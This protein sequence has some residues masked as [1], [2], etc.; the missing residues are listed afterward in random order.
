MPARVDDLLASAAFLVAHRGSG[1]NWP[2]HTLTAYR[3][4]LAAGAA[5][6]EISVRA[7][8]DKV[9]VCHHDANLERTTGRPGALAELSYAELSTLRVDARPWLGEATPLEPIS[10]VEDVLAALPVGCLAFVEDKDGTNTMAL[11]DLLDRQPD[12]TRRFVW[13]QWGPARQVKAARERGYRSWGYFTPESIDRVEEFAADHDALGAYVGQDDQTVARLVAMGKPVIVW[14]VHTRQQRDRLRAL[15]V[16][17]LMCSNVPYVSTDR[18]AA[19]AT[20][21][22]T[23][24]R[25][26]GDL[27]P[28]PE[29]GWQGQPALLPGNSRVKLAGPAATPRY[30]LGSLA[31]ITVDRYRLSVGFDWPGPVADQARAGISLGLADDGPYHPAKANPSGCVQLW[32]DGSGAIGLSHQPAG[33]ASGTEL[34]R[35]QAEPSGALEV[36][37]EV[38]A[39]ELVLQVGQTAARAAR[40]GSLGGYLW[41]WAE[42]V[43]AAGALVGPVSVAAS[44]D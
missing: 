39:G 31:P 7:T 38:G 27:P 17:G 15:G 37:L 18:S 32:R 4:A 9:L 13:K 36:G 29:S 21:F 23:A 25:A 10:R 41:L 2:E 19:S 42:Q 44:N 3:N 20:G 28:Q 24:Q 14:E 40:P 6:V 5:A 35:I 22:Q 26:A 43:G 30:S 33:A 11:L 8:A 34:A 1:D 12:A 16:Q